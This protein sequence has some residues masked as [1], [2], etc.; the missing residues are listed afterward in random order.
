MVGLSWRF[1]DAPLRTSFVATSAAA[2]A[3]LIGTA[4]VARAGLPLSTLYPWK[5]GAIFGAIILLAVG[6]IGAHHPFRRF[7]PANQTTT[8]RALL[9]A[10]VAGFVS[11]PA[12]PSIAATAAALTL[13][14]TGLDGV[15]GWLA[16]RSRMNSDF[17]ARFDMEVD[18]L[19]VMVLSM[20]AW[21]YGKAGLWVLLSGLLRYVFL[22]AGWL[23]PWLARP[24]MP[25]WRRQ[26][27][28]VVQI[29]ALN[30]AIVPAV[31]AT[32]S[33]WLSAVA[34]MALVYSFTVDVAWLWQQAA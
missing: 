21:Q 15:D 29:A 6:R 30:L 28:C 12:L 27:I 8:V 34:L 23:R 19:L 25:S 26:A 13:A 9:V 24:L 14:V 31:P 20:L 7:G 22:V 33:A 11:E 2:L 32:A 17:G 10:L 4:S 18:A 3:A 1:P 16:R 5:S